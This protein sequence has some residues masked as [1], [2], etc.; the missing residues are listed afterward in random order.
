MQSYYLHILF[1]RILPFSASGAAMQWLLSFGTAILLAMM[2]GVACLILHF[3]P[4][5]NLVLFGKS[6]SFYAFERRLPKI[7]R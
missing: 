1:L 6:R 7:L 3:I 5:A 4:F 2:V